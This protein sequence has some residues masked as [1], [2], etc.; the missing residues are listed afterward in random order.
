MAVNLGL[1]QWY[2]GRLAEAE[3]ALLEAQRAGRGSGNEYVRWTAVLFLSRIQTARGQ[4]RQ[5][6]ESY[7]Q[8]IEQGGQLPIVGLAHYD[9]GR[10]S[11]EWNDL[12][13]AADCLQRGIEIVQRGGNV[14]FE[15]G[16]YSALAFTKQAQGDSTAAQDALQ[17]ADQLLENPGIS[18]STRLYNLASQVAVALGQ[19]DLDA[20]SRVVERFPRLEE[21]GSFPNYLSLMLAQARVLLAQGQQAAAA[22]Q[23]EALH[24]MASHAGWRSTVTQARALQALATPDPD[25]A[26]TFLTEALARAEP[27]G[28]V[29][30]F[31]DAGE[32]MAALLREAAARDVA[33]EYVGKLLAAF[34]V[35]EYGRMGM[36]PPH[37]HAQPLLEPLSDR[38]L[39]V[40]YLL[41]DGQTNREIA[42]ALCVSINTVKTHLKNVY[43]KLGVSNRR[44]ATAKAEELGL[45]S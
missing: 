10:L 3:Q 9:L 43:G 6:A 41:T 20:A 33:T 22:G 8:M 13:A 2:R 18:P 7:R 40:L 16:G 31:V 37:P 42:Q 21:A 19:G 12:A 34:R 15:V 35:S 28:Y 39:D 29:R 11:Y 30:T 5:A 45:I 4:S 27:E 38:E 23:L 24:A 17:R 1:A 32:P 44:Q 26:F 36:E 25:Q 14:E